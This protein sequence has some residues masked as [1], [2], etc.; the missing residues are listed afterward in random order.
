VNVPNPI[1]VSMLMNAYY[2]INGAALATV[3]FRGTGGAVISYTLTI[4]QTIRDFYGSS[5]WG[6]TI[7]P[8]AGVNVTQVFRCIAP[9]ACTGAG[10]TGNVATGNAGT[11]HIDEQVRGVSLY[12]FFLFRAMSFRVLP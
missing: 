4:G 5:T 9:A 7:S 1:R 3:S 6:N 11:Y 2:P 8:V 10:G 12:G